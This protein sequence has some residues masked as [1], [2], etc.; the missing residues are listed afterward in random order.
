MTID[1]TPA[2]IRTVTR[3][4]ALAYPVVS[5]PTKREFSMWV[6]LRPPV[7]VMRASTPAGTSTTMLDAPALSVIGTSPVG[8]GS[9]NR[10]DAAPTEMRASVTFTSLASIVKSPAP[11][12]IVRDVGTSLETGTL[13]T[14]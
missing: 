4:F 5:E 6:E 13:V 2:L 8:C 1:V 7:V 10:T 12:S 14:P 11:A 3:S 9:T